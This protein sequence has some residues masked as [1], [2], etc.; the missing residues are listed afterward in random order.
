MLPF[1]PQ[2]SVPPRTTFAKHVMERMSPSVW[3]VKGLATS[4][5]L[6]HAMVRVGRPAGDE[7]GMLWEN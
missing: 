3:S 6:E 5:K 7:A 1:I 2:L 4:P